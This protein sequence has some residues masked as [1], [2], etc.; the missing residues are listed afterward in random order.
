[1]NVVDDV[2]RKVQLT[3]LEILLEVDRICKKHNLTYL[4]WA[5]TMLGAIRHKGF[6]PWDDDIDIAMKRDDYEK[7]LEICKTELSS[8]YFLQHHKTEPYYILQLAKIRIN[9]TKYVQHS[10]R[11]LNIHHGIWID[12]F[13]LDN[14]FPGSMKENIRC[15][16]VSLL[17]RFNTTRNLGVS[18]NSSYIKRILG[19]LLAKLSFLLINKKRYD[20]L[21]KYLITLFNS[22]NSE[23]LNELCLHA[24]KNY[25]K[26][27]LISVNDYYDIIHTNFEGHLFP[28]PRNYDLFLTNNYGEYNKLPPENER[29][30][31]HT[32]IGEIVV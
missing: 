10:R 7:F 5:G 24:S 13:P 26:R 20:M 3:Q 21:V 9:N 14:V 8:H 27:N 28:I 18:L 6:I 2:L 4:L 17:L 31:K 11:T 15:F 19:N 23:Y 29:I 16:I 1:M 25:I 32:S 30:P 12:I 22:K